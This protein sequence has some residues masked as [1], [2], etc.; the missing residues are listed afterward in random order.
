MTTTTAAEEKEDPQVKEVQALLAGGPLHAAEC[1]IQIP[2]GAPGNGQ[3][4]SCRP[5]SGETQTMTTCV[6]R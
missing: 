3:M 1:A 5:R 4:R 2:D 6:T